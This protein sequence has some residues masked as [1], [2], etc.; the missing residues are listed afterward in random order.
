MTREQPL[1]PLPVRS[2]HA[3]LAGVWS[4]RAGIPG[5]LLV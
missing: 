1:M 5:M 4:G 2:S 3:G